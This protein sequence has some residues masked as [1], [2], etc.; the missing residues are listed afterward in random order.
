MKCFIWKINNTNQMQNMFLE[1]RKDSGWLKTIFEKKL[2]G[3][4]DPP[5]HTPQW[6]KSLIFSISFLTGSLK[7]WNLQWCGK[8][9]YSF[10]NWIHWVR[11]GRGFVIT[12]VGIFILFCG[13]NILIHLNLRYPQILTYIMQI[14]AWVTFF[15]CRRF[16]PCLWSVPCLKHSNIFH[17]YCHS[18]NPCGFYHFIHAN[19]FP[20][21][22][23]GLV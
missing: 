20:C 6:Q 19:G 7:P 16:F 10:I 2:N 18:Y 14:D 1:S 3:R 21:P 13:E 23:P 22:W 4:R 5:T 17:E 9:H 8:N 15:P 12:L 11:T